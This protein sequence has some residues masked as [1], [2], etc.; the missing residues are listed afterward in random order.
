MANAVLE[1]APS[2]EPKF[3]EILGHKVK[4]NSKEH[5]ALLMEFDPDIK[6]M[7]QLAQ[8][9]M[10]RELPVIDVR[11][12]RAMPH[13]RFKPYQNMVM[14]S[15]II[16]NGGR[17]VIRYYDGC[18]SIF[19]S[20]QPKEKDVVDQFIAQTQKRRFLEGK[21]GCNGD[22]KMLLLYLYICSWNTESEFRTKTATGIFVPVNKS[23]LALAESSILDEQEKALSYAREASLQKMMIHADYLEIPLLDFD[24]GNELTEKEIR[25]EYRKAALRNAPKFLESYGNKA[26]EIKYYIKKALDSKVITNTFNA[27]KATWGTSNSV[28]CDISGLRSTEA[29]AQKVFEF[30]QTEEGDEFKI[31]L[32]ALY[33]Q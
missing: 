11:E 27:N 31:Q 33:N 29:I 25:I 21:F 14:T 30:S 7:F 16:W 9:N 20:Q 4:E 15:Q 24:S 8:E 18:E 28:I 10:Q 12:K 17:V 2:K 22:D 13:Q 1:T 6:Y 26:L 5:K 32:T 23:K 3:I 19:V